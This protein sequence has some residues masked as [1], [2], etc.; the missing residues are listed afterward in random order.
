L[1]QIS[2]TD[3]AFDHFRRLDFKS[4][5]WPPFPGMVAMRKWTGQLNK[6]RDPDRSFL[7]EESEAND[8]A[9]IEDR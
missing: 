6:R 7:E 2:G 5:G 4:L 9:L 1:K 8:D 3:R